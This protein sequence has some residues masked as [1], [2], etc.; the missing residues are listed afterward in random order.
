[1]KKAD[2]QEYTLIRLKDIKNEHLIRSF[3][4]ED[5]LKYLKLYKYMEE[6]DIEIDIDNDCEDNDPYIDM[7]GDIT[8]VFVNFGGKYTFPTIDIYVEVRNYR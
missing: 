7:I 8:D 4:T 3:F 6:N 2:C 5:P 1:M